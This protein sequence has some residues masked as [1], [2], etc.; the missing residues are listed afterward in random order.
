M[1]RRAKILLSLFAL[2]LVLAAGGWTLYWHGLARSVEG[3]L[4]TWIAERRAEGWHVDHDGVQRA[5]F[6]FTLH[7]TV[8]RPEIARPDGLVWRGAD[9]TATV[10]PFQPG[11]VTL[12]APGRHEVQM[13]LGERLLIEA[14]EVDGL[15]YLGFG[16]VTE[17]GLRLAQG[18][19]TAGRAPA[20][21]FEEVT[22]MVQPLP[23]PPDHT[24]PSLRFSL[25][26]LGLEM[27]ADFP[28]VLGPRIERARLAG[29]VMGR[30]PQDEGPAS[31]AAWRDDGGTVEIEALQLNWSTLSLAAEGTLALDRELQPEAA[32]TAQVQ[33]FQQA[34]EGFRSE[35]AIGRQ[36]AEM[37]KLVLGLIS[38]PGA[39]GRPSLTVPVTVQDRTLSVGPVPVTRLPRVVWE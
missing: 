16:G 36:E 28:S 32:L 13:P 22:A 35:G 15:V 4:A 33:G 30:M 21:G 7:L 24:Q 17:M 37:L 20:Q 14:Q 31:L 27:P 12:A 34:V 18:S 38:R 19:L 8:L 9:L 2:L 10:P 11:R 1:T 5:G 39:D 25:G 3:R 26:L 23:P 6:P 29:A